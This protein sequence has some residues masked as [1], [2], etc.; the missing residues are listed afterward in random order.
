LI[1]AKDKDCWAEEKVCGVSGEMLVA[2]MIKMLDAGD[3]M[4]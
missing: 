3:G 1:Y 4:N 2:G